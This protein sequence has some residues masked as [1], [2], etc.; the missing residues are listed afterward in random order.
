M[1]AFI[2]GQDFSP[3]SRSAAI[4]AARDAASH[5]ARLVLFHAYMAP[6]VSLK[7]DMDGWRGSIEKDAIRRMSA[8]R[9]ELATSYPDVQ[10]EVM[11]KEG[12][13][14]QTI[15][16]TAEELDVE[17]I[18]VG[19]HSRSEARAQIIGSVAQRVMRGAAVP[20]L[21]VKETLAL[22]APDNL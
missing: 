10:V 2:V 16:D 18:V 9:E 14:A 3:C 17:R 1:S 6:A 19:T 5:G 11:V 20:V 7:I 22:P 21:V 15:L 12:P 4:E 8:L 13:A